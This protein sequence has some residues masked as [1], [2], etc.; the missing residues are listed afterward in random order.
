MKILMLGRSLPLTRR[1]GKA[2]REQRFARHLA[3]SHR[4][5]L[6]FVTDDPNPVGAV[7]ALREEFGDLEFAVVPR[8]WKTLASAVSLATGD[9][10][11]LAYGPARGIGRTGVAVASL[12]PP[13]PLPG[14][15]AVLSL[16]P[17]ESDG[18]PAAAAV[19][20]R[21]VPPAVR[22]RLPA[23]RFLVV[24]G[25]LAPSAEGLARME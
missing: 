11:T 7:S 23:A 16:T 14:G 3:R 24:G 8:G 20:C 18:Q 6:A 9:S 13:L 12:T 1:G 2:T 19:F 5:T 10:C 25:E 4:L 17:L 21:P 22:R 15:P